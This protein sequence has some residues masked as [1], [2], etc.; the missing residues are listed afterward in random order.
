MHAKIAIH[1]LLDAG[2]LLGAEDDPRSTL[3]GLQ[4]IEDGLEFPALA[5]QGCQLRR[6]RCTRLEH[7]GE[8]AIALGWPWSPGIIQ[9]VLNDPHHHG[10]LVSVAIG[11]GIQ[12]RVVRAVL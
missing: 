2:G 5:I 10:V 7:G 6:R 12:T 4:L 3:M 11:E 1:L 8:Q 9:P